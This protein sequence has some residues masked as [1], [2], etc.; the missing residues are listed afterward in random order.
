MELIPTLMRLSF[1]GCGVRRTSCNFES[2]AVAVVGQDNDADSVVL[3]LFESSTGATPDPDAGEDLMVILCCCWRRHKANS[4]ALGSTHR[5]LAL[6]G[7]RVLHPQ[8]FKNL[9]FTTDDES[10]LL[11]TLPDKTS[12]PTKPALLNS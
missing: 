7:E 4:F 12:N 2:L 5:F 11:R 3:G 8:D 6:G 1:G 10:S 9:E